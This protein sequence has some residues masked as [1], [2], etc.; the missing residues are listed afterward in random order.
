MQSQ[1]N[2]LE[3]VHRGD[4]TGLNIAGLVRL[5]FETHPDRETSGLPLTGGDINNRDEQ[6]AFCRKYVESRGGT[7]VGTYDEPDTSAWKKKRIKQEDGSY[8]YRV[9]RPVFEGMLGDLRKSKT[10]SAHFVPAEGFDKLTTVDGAVVYDIDR[11]TRDHRHLEDAIEV[12]QYYHRP[13]LDIRGSLDLLTDNGRSA[14]RYVLNA[15]ASS[16]TD[17]SR[18][19]RDSHLARAARGIPVGGNRAFGWADDKRAIID[20]EAWQ[21]KA[22]ARMLLAGV[23]AS[24][25]IRKWNAAG[26]LTTKGNPWSRRTFVLMM[27]SPRMVG[28]RVY[29][30]MDQ[31]HHTRYLTDDQGNPVKGQYDAILDEHTWHSVVALLAGPDRPEGH[32]DIGK[33]KYMLSGILR[34]A[35][36]GGK[37]TGGAQPNNR[38]TYQCKYNDGGCGNCGSGNAI[39]AIVTK[40][41][42]ARLKE[43]HIEVETQPWPKAEELAT[44]NAGKASLLAQFKENSDMGPHIWPEVRKKEAA[45]AALV[46]ERTAYAKKHATPKSTNMVETWPSLEVEQRRAIAAEMFEAIILMPATKGSNRF[47]P[48]RLQVVWRQG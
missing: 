8:I 41:I 4:L 9:I 33:L 35:N 24:T 45:I 44:L 5:S 25:I 37:P 38:Y 34:C 21:I 30:P 13:I 1:P 23:K 6:E 48:E 20:K 42:L 18:R 47:N 28:Y 7:Y 12:V 22:A 26:R 2:T 3:R 15:R 46:K 19:L 36:C 39:D 31:P 14:A 17:T 40:L 29:G 32:E 10:E 11:L 27:T 43:Q 16:S